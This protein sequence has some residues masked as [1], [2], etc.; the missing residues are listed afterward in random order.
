MYSFVELVP[1]L[2]R[3]DGVQYFFSDR[4]NQD[5]VEEHFGRQR[6]RG[7]AFDN[8]T[9]EAYGFNERKILVAKSDMIR[10][11]RGNTRGRIREENEINNHDERELPKR[12]RKV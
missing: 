3:L 8:P 12:P 4:L 9:L 10:V 11:M 7:G 2:L 6:M 5:P 1:L